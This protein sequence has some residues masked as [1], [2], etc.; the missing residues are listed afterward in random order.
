[1]SRIQLDGARELL[2]DAIR[3]AVKRRKKL[4]Q[5]EWESIIFAYDQVARIVYGRIGNHGDDLIE[6]AKIRLA[7]TLDQAILDLDPDE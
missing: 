1:M 7:R 3:E 5:T 4:T 6:K 2:A